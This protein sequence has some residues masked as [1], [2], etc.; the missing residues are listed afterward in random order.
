[1]ETIAPRFLVYVDGEVALDTTIRENAIAECKRARTMG[2]IVRMTTVYPKG[3]IAKLE[4][5]I[6]VLEAERERERA[7]VCEA[8]KI[9][10]S[11]EA[12]SAFS[13]TGLF[14]AV[15]ALEAK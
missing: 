6:R 2:E 11:C 4:A 9:A 1:M 3:T 15:R 10:R 13:F 12:H 7:V 5:R 14:D 8:R